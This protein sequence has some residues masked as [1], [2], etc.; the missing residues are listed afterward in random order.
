MKIVCL[1]FLGIV[2]DQRGCEF[3]TI[4]GSQ[5][6][7]GNVFKYVFKILITKKINFFRFRLPESLFKKS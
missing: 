7:Q 6:R 2:A 1:L 4:L 5:D 3:K